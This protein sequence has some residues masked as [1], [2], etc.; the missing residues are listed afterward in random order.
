V[1]AQTVAPVNND[2]TQ[3]KYF[4]TEHVWDAK[5]KIANV[6]VLGDSKRGY[7]QVIP[8]TGGTFK[9]YNITGEVLPGGEDCQT[10]RPDGDIEL[11]ARYWLKTNDGYIIQ[12]NNTALMHNYMDGEKKQSYVKSVVDLEAPKNSP[13]DYLNHAIFIGTLNI[14]TL[15]KGEEP[16][17]VIG[18]YRIL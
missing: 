7:R 15:A 6:I 14:P 4:K 5:V 11:S 1:N 9:G 8:I 13:Y 2:S 17:V 12:V 10:V 18:V 3:Y 16:Y